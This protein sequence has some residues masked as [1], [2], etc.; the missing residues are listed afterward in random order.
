MS[1]LCKLSYREHSSFNLWNVFIT[2]IFSFCSEQ[3]CEV[4]LAKSVHVPYYSLANSPSSWFW[5]WLTILH[6]ASQKKRIFHLFCLLL[7]RF[8]LIY[9]NLLHCAHLVGFLYLR[10][11]VSTLLSRAYAFLEYLLLS[12]CLMDRYFSCDY[13]FNTFSHGTFSSSASITECI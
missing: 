4:G 7:L 13:P 2:H 5:Q 3:A 11:P 10:C 12:V 1:M 8:I 9:H 6:I